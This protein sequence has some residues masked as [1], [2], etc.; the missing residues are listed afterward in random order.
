MLTQTEYI[1]CGGG[2]CPH[3]GSGDLDGDS[4]DHYGSFVTQKVF[5]NECER[6]WEDYYTLTRYDTIS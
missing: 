2:E 4:F 1:A 6:S 3:C 5:C